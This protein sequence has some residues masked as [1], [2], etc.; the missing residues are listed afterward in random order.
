MGR[1]VTNPCVSRDNGKDSAMADDS[2]VEGADKDYIANKR[3]S[4]SAE[5]GDK[6]ASGAATEASHDD[7]L[8][9]SPSPLVASYSTTLMSAQ[10][11]DVLLP[12]CTSKYVER[13][14]DV[15]SRAG[16]E[17]EGEE[18][19]TKTGQLDVM[20]EYLWQVRLAC[21]ACLVSSFA[22]E[23]QVIYFALHYKRVLF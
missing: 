11:V 3:R 16:E 14:Y 9:G 21:F 6:P 12:V 20:L 13:M 22:L 4:A 2:V 7:L 10:L 15:T 17:L 18:L 1:F 23:S 19:A 5:R 8:D